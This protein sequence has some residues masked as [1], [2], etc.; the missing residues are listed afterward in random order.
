MNMVDI[1]FGWFA[2]WFECIE[3]IVGV[4]LLDPKT[5]PRLHNWA[6]NFK[7]VPVIKENLPDRK[8]L[9]VLMKSAREKLISGQ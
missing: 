8:R 1:A 2:Y 5:F 4:K 9:L 3:E 6:Q 7:Q